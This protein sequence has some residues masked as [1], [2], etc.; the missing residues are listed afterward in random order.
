M[1]LK[2]SIKRNQT[3]SGVHIPSK[4]LPEAQ[5]ELLSFLEHILG[6]FTVVMDSGEKSDCLLLF[7]P[8]SKVASLCA[9]KN[10]NQIV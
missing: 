9:E 6:N 1:E 2:R 5:V 7:S 3:Q 8:R 10:K 4:A